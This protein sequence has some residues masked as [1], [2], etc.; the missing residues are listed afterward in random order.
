MLHFK[1]ALRAIFLRTQPKKMP[2]RSQ[3][4]A[5]KRGRDMPVDVIEKA[6]ESAVKCSYISPHALFWASGEVLSCDLSR[7]YFKQ[8]CSHGMA[9]QDK[10]SSLRMARVS[11]ER[12]QNER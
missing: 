1:I 5:R 6:P 9:R 10:L 8:T 2:Y 7:H 12:R 3:I 4:F 11:P